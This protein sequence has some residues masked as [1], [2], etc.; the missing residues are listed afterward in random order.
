MLSQ[1]Q[2]Q[3]PGW[4]TLSQQN[5]TVSGKPAVYIRGTGTP[6]NIPMAMDNILVVSGN[7]Q[8]L[9]NMMCPQQSQQ[10]I[11]NVFAQV[12]ESWQIP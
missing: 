7:N 5:G 2:Q 12:A 4:Q 1:W 9:L 10:Q 8:F 11:Q 3:V 6:N